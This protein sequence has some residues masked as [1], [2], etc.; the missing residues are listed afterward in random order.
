MP[1]YGVA[2]TGLPD[3]YSTGSGQT[4]STVIDR[5][6]KYPVYRIFFKTSDTPVDIMTSSVWALCRH[7]GFRAGLGAEKGYYQKAGHMTSLHF[8]GNRHPWNNIIVPNNTVNLED[9]SA[10]Q[11]SNSLSNLSENYMP[12]ENIAAVFH[13][14]ITVGK[15]FNYGS[16]GDATQI[17]TI[18]NSN[19]YRVTL[20]GGSGSSFEGKAGGWV[21]TRQPTVRMVKPEGNFNTVDRIIRPESP[22]V[23]FYSYGGQYYTG[24]DVSG[25]KT[26][27]GTYPANTTS[28]EYALRS[29]LAGTR[30]GHWNGSLEVDGVTGNYSYAIQDD[31]VYG[32]PISLD[33][34]GTYLPLEN[35][36]S[37][38]QLN[39]GNSSIAPTDTTWSGSAS[40]LPPKY[41]LVRDASNNSTPQFEGGNYK[42]IYQPA[43][44]GSSIILET[45]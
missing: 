20:K 38:T 9:A 17:P 43:S 21:V 5:G 22:L 13:R 24:D 15:T 45:I 2:S 23:Y 28:F 27:D 32:T 33:T 40:N 35:V 18:K 19:A 3:T 12:I 1:A 42:D 37:I 36:A 31:E 11:I 44:A 14:N 7:K 25:A 6:S 26:S 10:S 4:D 30:I 34:G 41:S 29:G 16:T 39:S 8:A